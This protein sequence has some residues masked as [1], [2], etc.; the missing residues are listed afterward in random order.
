MFIISYLFWFSVCF[1]GYTYLGYPVLI[2]LLG[3]FKNR[4]NYYQGDCKLPKVSL[5]IAAHNEE[6]V[7]GQKIQNSITIDYPEELLSIVIVSDGSVDRTNEIINQ[8]VSYPRIKFLHYQPRRGKANALNF[9]VANSESEIIVFSDANIWYESGSIKY[10]VRNILDPSVGCVCGKVLLE[11]PKGSKE[12]IGE[13][14][15]MKYERFIHQNESRFNT[16]IGTDGAMYAIRRELFEQLPEDSIVDDF[17]I[18]MRV[19]EKGFRIVYEPKAIGYEEAASSVGQEFKR[20][21]RMIAGGFQS[22]NI[23][24]SVL[25]PMNHPIVFFQFVSHKFL[26]WVGSIFMVMLFLANLSLLTGTFYQITLA[27]Q[28]TFYACA[29]AAT[30]WKPLR[31]R[32]LFYFPYYFCSLNLAASIGMKRFLFGQQSVKWEK[33]TR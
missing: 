26:R 4:K 14:A 16:M 7:I 11:K 22:L 21:V 1:L 31:E 10:L 32:V 25:N 20:K 8:F 27:L 28:L 23:L 29:L 13:G 30:F 9:G 12:P 19:L 24:K 15:Y 33:I 17:I 5:I 18:A 2:A 6:K 3:Q